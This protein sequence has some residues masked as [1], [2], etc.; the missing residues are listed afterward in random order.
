MP[1]LAMPY[2]EFDKLRVKLS[3]SL[4]KDNAELLAWWLSLYM[5][6]ESVTE[7][8]FDDDIE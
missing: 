6:E 5:A 7:G 3:S 4:V 8:K 1:E 2:E